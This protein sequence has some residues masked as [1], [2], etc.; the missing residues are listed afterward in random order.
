MENENTKITGTESNST[1]VA[2]Y[3]SAVTDKLSKSLLRLIAANNSLVEISENRL[4]YYEESPTK[5]KECYDRWVELN[6]ALKE[7][8]A[9]TASL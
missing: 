4:T 9:A 7:A 6:F 5:N 8:K 1:T 3:N 2:D